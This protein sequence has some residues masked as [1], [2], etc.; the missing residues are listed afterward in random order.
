VIDAITALLRRVSVGWLVAAIVVSTA[1]LGILG[2]T[3]VTEWQHSAQL[4]AQ[5]RAD[6]GVELLV[7][8]LTRD[9]RG[10]QT[11]VLP[12]LGLEQQV[13]P[14]GL[15]VH[16]VGSAFA[17]YPYP[18]A[19][20][21][22]RSPKTAGP[23]TFYTRAD[24]PAPWLPATTQASRFPVVV[25]SDPAMSSLLLDHLN[26]DRMEKRRF[27][28]F[29][30]KLR[31]ADYQVVALLSYTDPIR[32]HLVAAAG[33][34]VSL[35][36]VRQRYF[37]EFTQQITRIQ[38]PDSGLQLAIFDD[39]GTPV[40]AP[41]RGNRDA[42][43]ST[44][45]FPM[46]FFDPDIAGLDPQPDVPR[47]MWSARATVV[48]DRALLA[49]RSGATRTLVIA[50][51]STLLLAA[52]FALTL[53]AARANSALMTM[54]SEF[55]SAVTHELKTPIATIRAVGDSVASGRVTDVNRL[56]DYAQLVVQE[57]KRL[58]RL[59][60][61]LLAYSRITDVT[62]AYHFEP[63]EVGPLVDDAL[64]GFSSQL[65]TNGFQIEL[66]VPPDLPPVRADRTAIGL[67][68]DNVIDNAIR[69]SPQ[70]HWLGIRAAASTGGVQVVISDA[71]IGIARDEI[72]H[73]VRK[74]F[75]GRRAGSGGSGLG[76]AIAKRIVHDHGGTMSIESTVGNGT[77]V[78]VN[79][80]H[81]GPAAH[82]NPA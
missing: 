51:I 46:V 63:L 30:L 41:P 49:A 2:Y 25:A 44:R 15:D 28:T 1:T 62:E 26:S 75:R 13:T 56:K 82:A 72:D 37:P 70:K 39:G 14:P 59:F 17:R 33:F 81:A 61:N 65:S 11:S 29:N 69:Y 23:M 74:F 47:K 42:P 50:T 43:V 24:R 35:D 27:A 78:R 36:W 66:D 38:G 60:D 45:S 31:G 52:G 54:R 10:V 20:F 53:Y 71:G 8:A 58:A 21:A 22:T 80:P 76:L 57:S 77:T 7:S 40:V 18:E 4:L 5:R 9:M 68:L 73:V 67:L 19:F 12:H 48:E 34:L 79:L 64:R 3:A 32:E 6:A 55:V 16:S